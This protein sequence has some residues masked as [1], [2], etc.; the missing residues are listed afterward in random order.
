MPTD[1]ASVC[2]AD[3]SRDLLEDVVR[4]RNLFG[5]LRQEMGP[6]AGLAVQSLLEFVREAYPAAARRAQAA[7]PA[8]DEAAGALAAIWQAL[9][10]PGEPP[11]AAHVLHAFA[12]AMAVHRRMAEEPAGLRD[13]RRENQRM[14]RSLAAVADACRRVPV[15]GPAG[16]L[17]G[18]I[19]QTAREGLGEGG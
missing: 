1:H 13:L 14:R 5:M 16:R 17:A 15:A 12:S 11:D 3:R 6:A 18:E 7:E 2:E 4:F 10:Q 19:L 8:F 9:G